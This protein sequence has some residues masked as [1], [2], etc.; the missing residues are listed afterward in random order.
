MSKVSVC[1]LVGRSLQLELPGTET[2]KGIKDAVA[3]VWELDPVSF[4]LLCKGE[5]MEEER[6]LESF[7]GEEDTLE[8]QLLKFDP[9][10]DLG[11]F[12]KSMHKGI[13][14]KGPR[15]S[16]KKTMGV[17]DSNNVFL[18]HKILEPCFY[19]FEVIRSRDEMSFGVTYDRESMEKVSG[20][21]NINA[22]T[23]W[24][25]SKKAAMPVFFFGGEK[26]SISSGGREGHP[27][28]QEGDLVAVYCDPE[29]RL[30]EFYCNS[31]FLASTESLESPLPEFQGSPLFMYC[32]VD[33]IEDEVKIKRFGPGRPY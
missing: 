27:G 3:K 20:Y 8:L 32:M 18:R 31:K 29:S 23:T 14:L 9:L 16:L 1:D 30:C 26:L 11:I 7:L 22:K 24:I 19:E 21:S 17:P 10:L 5:R 15:S 12:E 13:D 33:Q 25:F 28:V 6:T 2:G 4:R